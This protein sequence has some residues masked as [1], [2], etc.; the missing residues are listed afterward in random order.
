MKFLLW[1][2]SVRLSVSAT[3]QVRPVYK[4]PPFLLP[5][6]YPPSLPMAR[7]TGSGHL[8]KQTASTNMTKAQL[9]ELAN[10][11][12]AHIVYLHRKNSE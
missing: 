9:L 6:L 5:L 10:A 4:F 7:T 11:K 12:E 8:W 1:A 3:C 2:D